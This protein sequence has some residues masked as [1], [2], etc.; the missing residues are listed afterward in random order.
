MWL[1][2]DR[3]NALLSLFG[4]P[5]ELLLELGLRWR[6]E[7]IMKVAALQNVSFFSGVF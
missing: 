3:G 5:L 4:L 2:A 1:A 7:G 6:R